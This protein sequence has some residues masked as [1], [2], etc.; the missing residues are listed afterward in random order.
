MKFASKLLQMLILLLVNF[1]LNTLIRTAV[2]SWLVTWPLAVGNFDVLIQSKFDIKSA[3]DQNR[4]KFAPKIQQ[5]PPMT[6][7]KF[8]SATPSRNGNI[9]ILCKWTLKSSS[10]GSR[11][12]N[13]TPEAALKRRNIERPINSGRLI[14]RFESRDCPAPLRHTAPPTGS[15]TCRPKLFGQ[16][17]DR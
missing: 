13:P 6:L 11:Q 8:H 9:Q 12:T 5:T 2:N 1:H 10:C 14:T 15:A 17:V 16:P 3:V 4:M 7:V